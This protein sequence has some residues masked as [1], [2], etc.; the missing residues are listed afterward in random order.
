MRWAFKS[1]NVVS[2]LPCL[3]NLF[4]PLYSIMC[5]DFNTRYLSLGKYIKNQS[6][7]DGINTISPF[8]IQVLQG[9]FTNEKNKL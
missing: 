7:R 9:V 1:V 8:L 2:F 3:F 5:I 6:I 4:A